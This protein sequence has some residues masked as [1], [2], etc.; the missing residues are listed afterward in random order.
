MI[1]SL[2]GG[3]ELALA[4]H[5][6]IA[7]SDKKTGLGLPEVMLG[8]LPGAG[9]TQRTQKLTSIPTTLDMALTGKTVKAGRAK[10]MGL[11]DLLVDPLGPGLQD[12][13]ATTMEY[14]EKVAVSVAKDLST[15][16]LKVNREKTTYVEKAMAFVM[17]IDFVKNQ[18]FS[19]AK[20]QVMKMSGGLYPAPLR[21]SILIRL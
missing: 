20:Q 17:D 11:I 5:Y 12:A 15:G 9:G 6:R 16:K 18:V 4:C 19:K 21:V 2:G 14:L 7:T 3:L 10:K 13:N 8:L 1:F